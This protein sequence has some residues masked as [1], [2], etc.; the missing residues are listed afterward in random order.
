MICSSTSLFRFRFCYR[1]CA[2]RFAT[3]QAAP[4]RS[5]LR[6]SLRD[7][8]GTGGIRT[9]MPEARN[10]GRRKH[11]NGGHPPLRLRLCLVFHH[12]T[13]L[14]PSSRPGEYVTNKPFQGCAPA[15]SRHWVSKP[16]RGACLAPSVYL[17]R[18]YQEAP[19]QCRDRT[20]RPRRTA[21]GFLSSRDVR[22]GFVVRRIFGL[23][24]RVNTAIRLRAVAYRGG[25]HPSRRFTLWR[26]RE[27]NPRPTIR[28][29]RI[30]SH[31]PS[32]VSR[33]VLNGRTRADGVNHLS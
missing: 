33:P 24:R 19:W 17:D 25:H 4:R 32:I 1:I 27:S 15:S 14:V 18:Y 13:T 11:P 7:P 2:S 22:R 9:R 5:D 29:I 16:V 6:R 31:S 10:S 3:A 26:R 20:P 28:K 21:T 12:S 23:P 30:Y 8:F